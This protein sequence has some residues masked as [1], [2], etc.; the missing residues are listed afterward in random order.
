MTSR[1]GT[2]Y[3]FC[4]KMAAGKSTLATQLAADNNALLLAEDD[5]LATLYP[6]EIHDVATYGDKAGK[7]RA[8]IQPMVQGM[9]QRGVNVVM[10]FPANTVQQRNW[11]RQVLQG[12]ATT[13][14]ADVNVISS[15][16]ELHHIIC[17][18]DLCKTQLAKRAAEL[19]RATDT[20]EMFVAMSC[21]YQ[22]VTTEERFNVIE[23]RRS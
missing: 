4:G 8:A 11:F 5:L 1:H 20:V 9:L 3:F 16:H 7:V 22:P 18:D 10:D 21:F 13:D 2:L 23:H 14:H 17:D 19:G 15:P 12:T 6:Q